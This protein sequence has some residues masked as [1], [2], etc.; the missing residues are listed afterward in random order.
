MTY[1][2]MRALHAARER[3]AEIKYD[4]DRTTAK[5][6]GLNEELAEM[7]EAITELERKQTKGSD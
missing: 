1:T 5:L 2:L 6:T 7:D 4:I 3:R